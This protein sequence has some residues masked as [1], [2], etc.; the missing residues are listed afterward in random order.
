MIRYNKFLLSAL[1]LILFAAETIAQTSTTNSSYSRFG[2]GVMNEQAQGFNKNMGGVGLGLR[3]GNIANTANP[4][5]YSAIDSATFIFDVGMSTN[6]ASMTSKG[7]TTKYNTT[8]LDYVN[9]GLRL[10]KN[11]GLSFGFMPYTSVGYSFYST[12]RIGDNFISSSLISKN[13]TH[14]GTGG[15]HQAYIGLGAEVYK[16]LSVGFNASLL[17]GDIS[18]SV[19][20]SF[21]EGGSVDNSYTGLH[22]LHSLEVMTYKIDFGVQYPIRLSLQDWLTV[23][24]T[25][26]LGHAINSEGLLY[27]YTGTESNVEPLRAK[28]AYSLPYTY[29]LG[30]GWTHKNTLQAGLDFKHELWGSCTTPSYDAK[31]NSYIAT[32]D[33]YKNRVRLAAGASYTPDPYSKQYLKRIRYRIG[34]NYASPNL[35]INGSTGPR[36]YGAT[37]GVGLP[38]TNRYT[39]RSIVNI[40][41]QWKRIAPMTTAMITENFFG[42]NIGLTFCDNW[43]LKYKIQ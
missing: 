41:V 23:G 31:T 28:N 6:F 8:N 37:A 22:S 18:N 13:T 14:E 5:S 35:I 20:E 29:G 19:I 21:T 36:E 17:W 1:A 27:R 32:K 38:I 3:A 7:Q 16:K 2:L 40:G 43:F 10:A 24:A 34:V 12:S 26:G 42:I 33:Q 9:A 15:I 39:N 25:T 30:L 11:I 4:A